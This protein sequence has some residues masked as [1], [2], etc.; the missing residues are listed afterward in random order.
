[1][2]TPTMFSRRRNIRCSP[3]YEPCWDS[4]RNVWL[5]KTCV[6]VSS[7]W[8]P[9][10]TFFKQY[11]WNPLGY[12]CPAF[13]GTLLA[14]GKVQMGSALTANVMFYGRRT[15][16]VLPLTYLLSPV[17]RSQGLL[18]VLAENEAAAAGPRQTRNTHLDLFTTQTSTQLTIWQ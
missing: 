14:F 11:P 8:G 6:F 9:L 16:L 18:R 10:T 17:V 13:D 3:F 12:C 1:M 4:S 15:L 5:K 7:N 2:L